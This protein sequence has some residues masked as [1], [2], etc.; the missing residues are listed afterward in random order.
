MSSDVHMCSERL[1]AVDL[2][3]TFDTHKVPIHSE[4]L[5]YIYCFISTFFLTKFLRVQ[6]FF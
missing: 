4:H 2:L 3:I 5:L 1:N 6:I